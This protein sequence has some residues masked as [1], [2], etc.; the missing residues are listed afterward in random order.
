MTF[1]GV[2]VATY[3]SWSD[4]AITV[5]VPATAATGPV[6]VTVG[7]QASNGVTFTVTVPAPSITV[8]DPASGRNGA[9]VAIT[10]T[11]FGASQGTGTVTFNGVAATPTSWSG[12]SITVPVPAH[13]DHGDRHS[14]GWGTDKQRL[15]LHRSQ[16]AGDQC[17]EP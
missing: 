8:L 5:P 11:N 9:S 16:R 3:T 6:V 12:T 13:C 2:T 1:N 4:T 17:V 15:G 7:A 14:D 10:G